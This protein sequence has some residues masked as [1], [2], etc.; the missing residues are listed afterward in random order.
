MVSCDMKGKC[1]RKPYVEVYFHSK[2]CG[3]DCPTGGSHWSYLCF[4]HFVT[5]LVMNKIKRSG[6]GYAY[7]SNKKT[8]LGRLFDK[9]NKGELDEETI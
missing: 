7:V 4:F 9:L 8:L 3:S 6:R 5:D 1:N 2:N